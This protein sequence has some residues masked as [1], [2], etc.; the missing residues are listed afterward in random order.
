MEKVDPQER[1]R[2]V[3]RSIFNSTR[4]FPPRRI[5][6]L[7]Q[8]D[9][10]LISDTGIRYSTFIRKMKKMRILS[11]CDIKRPQKGPA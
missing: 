1:E 11:V 3:N 10:I 9:T 6:S 5:Y 4:F 2:D 7:A 8:K